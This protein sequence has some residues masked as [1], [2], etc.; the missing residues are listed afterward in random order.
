MK[1]DSLRFLRDYFSTMGRFRQTMAL[2]GFDAIPADT[3]GKWRRRGGLP[4]EWILR[5]L[6]VLEI[7]HGK[8]VALAR[9][10]EAQNGTS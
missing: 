9:Y 3:A 8:P 10:L 1:F 2:Y 6:C 5:A 4:S 7:E